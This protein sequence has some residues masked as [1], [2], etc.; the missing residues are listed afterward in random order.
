LIALCLI[1]ITAMWLALP[2]AVDCALGSHLVITG[3]DV[4]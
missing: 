2:L 3:T 1:T 4:S